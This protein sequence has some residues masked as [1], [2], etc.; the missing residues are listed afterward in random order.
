MV[1]VRLSYVL[2]QR[3]KGGKD[4]LKSISEST[5]RMLCRLQKLL[6]LGLYVKNLIMHCII[7]PESLY[8]R[9]FYL[10][11]LLVSDIVLFLVANNIVKIYKL[12]F[13]CE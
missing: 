11:M 1:R 6:M 3:K 7:F 13:L 9:N 2:Y 5:I 8:L 12:L 10:D 4:L